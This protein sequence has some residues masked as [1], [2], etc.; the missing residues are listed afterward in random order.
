MPLIVCC[1]LVIVCKDITPKCGR[2]SGKHFLS[3]VDTFSLTG[4]YY[5]EI[6]LDKFDLI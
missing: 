3:T 1:N 6:Y 5:L 2:T 4:G